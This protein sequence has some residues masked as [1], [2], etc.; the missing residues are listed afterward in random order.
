MSNSISGNGKNTFDMED[1][2][3]LISV[4]DDKFLDLSLT[5]KQIK[6][7]QSVQT[8][9]LNSFKDALSM[10]MN[11]IAANTGVMTNS[12]GSINSSLAAIE[13]TNSKLID[14]LSNG[15]TVPLAAVIFILIVFAGLFI[16]QSFLVG[17]GH[18]K[19]GMSGIE[20]HQNDQQVQQKKEGATQQQQ[21]EPQS[22]QS[23]LKKMP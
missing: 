23:P 6:D 4:F 3:E 11:T 13:H 18:A 1:L 14:K 10:N 12:L 7:H 16:S 22:L 8:Q 2:K 20:I 19:I 21:P 17:G 9:I 15:M 5:Q